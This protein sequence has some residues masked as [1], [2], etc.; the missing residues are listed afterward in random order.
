MPSVR[1]IP[2]MRSVFVTD[3]TALAARVRAALKVAVPVALRGTD[4]TV[5][6]WAIVGDRQYIHEKMSEYISRLGISHLI[7]RAGISGVDEEEQIRSHQ[8]LLEVVANL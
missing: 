5:D 7:V 3:D 6:D 1:T 2:V 8:L 4:S